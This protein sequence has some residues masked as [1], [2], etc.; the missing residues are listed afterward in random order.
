MKVSKTI[1]FKVRLPMKVHDALDFYTRLTSE[2][3]SNEQEEEAI[4][5]YVAHIIEEWLKMEARDPKDAIEEI[6]RILQEKLDIEE[7]EP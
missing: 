3:I 4:S 2:W 6:K 7:V 5:G 1:E